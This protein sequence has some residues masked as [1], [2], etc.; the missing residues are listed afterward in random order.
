[1]R[2]I[3][4]TAEQQ[5]SDLENLKKDLEGVGSRSNLLSLGRGVAAALLSAKSAL[6]D[7]SLVTQWGF[8]EPAMCVEWT[9][10]AVLS[11]LEIELNAADKDQNFA[12]M[13]LCLLAQSGLKTLSEACQAM[14]SSLE[15]SHPSAPTPLPASATPET[16]F[17]QPNFGR[18]RGESPASAQT[19]RHIKAFAKIGSSGGMNSSYFFPPDQACHSNRKDYDPSSVNG[20][21]ETIDGALRQL[22]AL[23]EGEP[24]PRV[25][26]REDGAKKSRRW[27]TREVLVPAYDSRGAAT[28][29]GSLHRSTVC[30]RREL[31]APLRNLY[32][33][34]VTKVHAELRDSGS[35]TNPDKRPVVAALL[36]ELDAAMLRV[37]AMDS[38]VQRYSIQ[39]KKKVREDVLREIKQEVKERRNNPLHIFQC[40]ANYA[41]QSGT[42]KAFSGVRSMCGKLHT[43]P[44]AD[45]MASAK[46]L[47]WLLALDDLLVM[48]SDDG[49]FVNLR[50][51]CEMEALRLL[52]TE[53]LNNR[54]NS[55]TRSVGLEENV[56]WQDLW[57]VKITLDARRVTKKNCQTEVMMIFIPNGDMGVHRCQSAV[58]IRTIAVWAGKDSKANV[59]K[60]LMP[61]LE[62]ISDL[63]RNGILYS[64]QADTFLG[65]QALYK[66]K[67]FEETQSLGLRRAKLE[68]W[69]PADMLAQSAVIGHGCA[70]DQFCSH[71]HVTKDNRHLPFQLVRLARDTNF[72]AL[73]ET[74]DL[75]PDTLHRI[76]LP[77]HAGEGEG[78]SW[79]LTEEGLRA[80][81]Q[82]LDG[83]TSADSAAAELSAG[84]ESGADSSGET[85]SAS[86][87]KRG[88]AGCDEGGFG[89]RHKPASDIPAP[90]NRGV[91]ASG[92]PPIPP[93]PAGTLRKKAASSKS[94][95]SAK[96]PAT[97]KAASAGLAPPAPAAGGGRMRADKG[98]RA[99]Q[100]AAAAVEMAA[101]RRR[102]GPDPAL[103][104]KLQGWKLR[105]LPS[106]RCSQCLL[107]ADTIV[108]IIPNNGF[109]RQ[110]DFLDQHWPNSR[111]DHFPFCAL[112]CLM[113]ITEGLFFNICQFALKSGEPTIQRLNK[114]LKAIGMSEKKQFK[115]EIDP[116][117]GPSFYS[118]MTF[119]GTECLRLLQRDNAGP[120]NI[121]VLLRSVWPSGDAGD[122][123]DAVNFVNRSVQLWGKWAE[124]VELM[125]ER[126]PATLR[127]KRGFERFGKVCREFV[128]MYQ[129]MY[130]KEHCKSFYLHTLLHHAGD[131]MRALEKAGMCLGMMSNSGAER[132]H[133]NGRAAFKRSL[134]GGCWRKQDETL[135]EVP[136]LSAYLTLREI[137]VWQYGSDLLSHELAV[138]AVR[139]EAQASDSSI[140][141]RRALAEQN[142]KAAQMSAGHSDSPSEAAVDAGDAGVLLDGSPSHIRAAGEQEDAGACQRDSDLGEQTAADVLRSSNADCN[143][144]GTT[145]LNQFVKSLN[146][147]DLSDYVSAENRRCGDSNRCRDSNSDRIGSWLEKNGVTADF[148]PEDG[149]DLGDGD[150]VEIEDV[151]FEGDESDPARN[152]V[153]KAKGAYMPDWDPALWNGCPCDIS[154]ESGA[155][156][157][158]RSTIAA[159]SEHSSEDD[160][161][162]ACDSDA[163][164]FDS[165]PQMQS[166]DDEGSA[167]DPAYDVDKELAAQ[168]KRRRDAENN[169]QSGI[170]SNSETDAESAGAPRSIRARDITKDLHHVYA[171]RINKQF[172]GEQDAGERR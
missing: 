22:G 171:T 70:G 12:L 99:A 139:G 156:S 50:A 115:K 82:V 15:Q 73:A 140:Q 16:P 146:A 106:C 109:C 114:A 95:S 147:K 37:V 104:R 119:L 42:A 14:R 10:G 46:R 54:L 149:P 32:I 105:H 92:V 81:T 41:R 79:A 36:D 169:C 94:S 159:W 126:D 7:P 52:Q 56:R 154:E 158:D 101:R 141:S 144:Q 88:R 86:R 120:I 168:S 80:C 172:L 122:T 91:T 160:C 77:G 123:P 60:N 66:D 85:N 18:S 162:G 166:A 57:H 143:G 55:G 112:H 150:V 17:P 151:P 118:K 43:A 53:G 3:C 107:P 65:V 113:R 129:T 30:R 13:R 97:N 103:F 142:E 39:S 163:V 74:Y 29:S 145:D 83:E 111:R 108:R 33:E 72:Q 62:G 148:C 167:D 58:H 102:Q 89:K 153:A 164:C 131:F 23:H 117:G 116:S 98:A 125:H 2:A 93:A 34:I 40:A 71:C 20:R 67:T 31:T 110:S 135:K 165:L 76:N 124:L 35:H 132:R 128:C 137:M 61:I 11:T 9:V 161:E 59:Q 100:A 26:R 138:R 4:A 134:C 49:F 69:M 63:E 51:A 136:N 170:S 64:P 25:L 157:E 84:S 90:Q 8:L 130:H 44:S 127:R 27:T 28:S 155:G 78:D 1:M 133:A 38:R 48:P 19:A 5:R 6:S 47:L 152:Y 75:F 24:P 121:E 21:M 45:E 68:F 96:R 87:S